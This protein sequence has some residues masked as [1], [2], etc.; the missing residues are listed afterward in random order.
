MK[1]QSL[2]SLFTGHCY[3][4]AIGN[5]DKFYCSIQTE[6]REWV[7]IDEEVYTESFNSPLMSNIINL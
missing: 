2:I 7:E 4:V 6:G 1:S 5:D 3:I